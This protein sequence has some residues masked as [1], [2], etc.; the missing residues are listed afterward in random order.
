MGR[1][2]EGGRRCGEE[3][4]KRKEGGEGREGGREERE[5]GK[6]ERKGRERERKGG[7]VWVKVDVRTLGIRLLCDAHVGKRD[8]TYVFVV[9][10][11]GSTVKTGE[12]RRGGGQAGVGC[13]S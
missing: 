12:N 9:A 5:E 3:R 1:E 7:L 11:A 6:R 13:N 8:Q 10:I 4:R 2:G